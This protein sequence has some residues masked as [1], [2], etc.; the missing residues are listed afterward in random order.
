M[1]YIQT[2]ILETVGCIVVGI[3]LIFGVLRSIQPSQTINYGHGG[4]LESIN[5]PSAIGSAAS[6]STLTTAYTGASSTTILAEGLPN[7]VVAGSY[8][9]KSFGSRMYM[10]VERSIDKGATYEPYMTLTPE[11]SDVLVNSSGSSTTNGSPFIIP[12]NSTTAASGT[13]I[14]FSFD[15]TLVADYVRI[16]AKES[17]TSTAGTLNAQM[18]L[19]SN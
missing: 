17:T 4:P 18:L 19:T 10:L 6:P 13:S 3:L 1:T 11:T 7:I 15:L 16:S 8:L 12:G 2:R 5:Y 9:P 14:G